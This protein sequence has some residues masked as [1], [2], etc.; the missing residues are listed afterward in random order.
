MG[1]GSMVVMWSNGEAGQEFK[2]ATPEKLRSREF[3][4]AKEF[5]SM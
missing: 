3:R 5:T 4:E 1:R 2:E